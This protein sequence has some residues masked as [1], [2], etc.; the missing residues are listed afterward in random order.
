MHNHAYQLTHD[1]DCFFEINGYPIHIATNGGIVS[2]KLGTVEELIEQQSVVTKL[3]HSFDYELNTAFLESLSI[4]DFPTDRDFAEIDR[5][6]LYFD[7]LFE[8]ERYHNIP[9]HWKLY[10]HSFVEMA[11]KGFWSYDR[12][13]VNEYGTDMYVL[14]ASPKYNGTKNKIQVGHQFFIGQQQWVGYILLHTWCSPLMDLIE[15]SESADNL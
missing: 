8:N 10:S 7:G 9:F 4:E 13:D 14:V 5:E 12:V 3:E 11:K 2:S 15:C 6:F 1:M